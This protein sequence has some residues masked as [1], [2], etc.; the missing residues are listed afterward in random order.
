MFEVS[1]FKQ[2]RLGPRSQFMVKLL[3]VEALISLV[4]GKLYFVKARVR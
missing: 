1:N 2:C 4:G 3:H